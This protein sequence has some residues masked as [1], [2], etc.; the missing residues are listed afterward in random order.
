MWVVRV[1]PHEQ[2]FCGLGDIDAVEEEADLA[3]CW[4]DFVWALFG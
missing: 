3:G 1:L 2:C 4:E